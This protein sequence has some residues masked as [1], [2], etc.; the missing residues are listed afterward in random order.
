MVCADAA[1][2]DQAESLFPQRRL[3]DD[4]I[5]FTPALH[6]R[7]LEMVK[8]FKMGPVFTPPA[9]STL[10]GPLGTLTLGGGNGGTN[11]PGGSF[12]PETHTAFL[13]ACNSCFE[14]IGMV[15]PPPG[16]SDMR[17]IEGS[18]TPRSRWWEQAARA[19]G[20]DTPLVKAAA[21]SGG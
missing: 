9:L 16:L 15:P 21:A 3:A 17:Y 6:A 8:N 5:D 7:A 1:F 14:P 20:A 10:P 18:R 11:W 13:F 19:P 4:F 12:N 2:P